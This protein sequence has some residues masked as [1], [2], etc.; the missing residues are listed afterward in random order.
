M[1]VVDILSGEGLRTEEAGTLDEAASKIRDIGDQ[2]AAAIVDIGLPDGSG[3]DLVAEIRALRPD[4]PIILAT[5]HVEQEVRDRF[6]HDPRLQILAKPFQP[7]ALV[8]ALKAFGIR[9]G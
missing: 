4:M 9:A 7:E 1:L 6:G 3:G 5:G 8:A 2:L